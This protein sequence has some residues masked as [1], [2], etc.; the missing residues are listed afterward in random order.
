[1]PS[2]EKGETTPPAS[3]PAPAAPPSGEASRRLAAVL[4]ALIVVVALIAGAA[5]ILTVGNQQEQ[6]RAEHAVA[7]L[8]GLNY[9][10]WSGYAVRTWA[11]GTYTLN[12]T[13]NE[14]VPLGETN[15]TLQVWLGVGRFGRYLALGEAQ[16]AANFTWSFNFTGGSQY[17]NLEGLWVTLEASPVDYTEG[18]LVAEG[19]FGQGVTDPDYAILAPPGGSGPFVEVQ[20]TAHATVNSTVVSLELAATNLTPAANLTYFAWLMNGTKP[21]AAGELTVNETTGNG[22]LDATMTYS[23]E[24][25][26]PTITGVVIAV[27]IA[28]FTQLDAPGL[29]VA[30][31]TFGSWTTE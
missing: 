18:M 10:T 4:I 12:V 2:E 21:I 30:T 14:T 11:G 22:T 9:S 23:T 1:M 15:T 19:V 20:G 27:Q 25:D 29:L 24:E 13:L 3:G 17:K 8:A 5:Y 7:T 16:Q 6:P 28:G 26:V 31:G